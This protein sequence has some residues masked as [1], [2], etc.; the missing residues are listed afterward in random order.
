MNPDSRNETMFGKVVIDAG[1]FAEVGQVCSGI[2][3]VGEHFDT[4][5][6]SQT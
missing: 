6:R 5:K 3:K 1:S 4:R 2:I